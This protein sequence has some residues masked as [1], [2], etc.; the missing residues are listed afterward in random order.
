MPDQ[1]K[2]VFQIPEFLDGS[3]DDRINLS[4]KVKSRCWG[5]GGFILKHGVPLTFAYEGQPLQA[6]YHLISAVFIYYWRLSIFAIHHPDSK[7][8]FVG[9]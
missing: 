1:L 5:A 4:Q 7:T 3:A 8:P 9:H 6:N 2:H